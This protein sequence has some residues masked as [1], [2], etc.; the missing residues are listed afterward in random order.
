MLGHALYVASRTLP[1]ARFSIGFQEEDHRQGHQQGLRRQPRTQPPG[2]YAA[3]RIAWPTPWLTG[4]PV[5]EYPARSIAS[6]TSLRCA[7]SRVSPVTSTRDT[8]E[9]QTLR[10]LTSP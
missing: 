2:S 6:T 8:P 7:T 5:N 1:L 3:N 4:T 9:R 10:L